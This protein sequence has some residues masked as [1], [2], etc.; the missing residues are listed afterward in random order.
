VH[1]LLPTSPAGA[2]STLKSELESHGKQT[3]KPSNTK[4]EISSEYL[5]IEDKMVKSTHVESIG[6]L[7]PAVSS[8][9]KPMEEKDVRFPKLRRTIVAE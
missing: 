7:H 1:C 3:T 4:D 2:P 6:D 5:V 9:S 8:S